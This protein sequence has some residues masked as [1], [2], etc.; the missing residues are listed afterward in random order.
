MV[1]IIEGRA[2]PF[3]ELASDMFPG[4]DN[5]RQNFIPFLGAGVSISGRQFGGGLKLTGPPPK[6]EDMDETIERLGLKGKG[7]TFMEMAILLAYLVQMAEEHNPLE[8]AEQI[9]KRLKEEEDYPPS[10]GEL[11]ELFSLRAHYSMFSSISQM[12]RGLFPETLFSADEEEQIQTLQ[13]LSKVTRIASPPD[14]LTSISSYYENLRGRDKLWGLLYEVISPKAQ[15][16]ETHNLLADAAQLHLSKKRAKDYLIITTNYDCLM[17]QA[18]DQRQVPYIVLTTKKSK[19]PKVL[20]RCSQN[21]E[22]REDLIKDYRDTRTPSN[23][24]LVK[25]QSTVVIYK[26]HGCLSPEFQFADEGLVVSDN[27]YVEYISWMSK[28]DGIIPSYV[29]ELMRD[30]PFWFLGYSLNDWN[31]RSI[32]EMVK[33]KSNPDKKNIRDISVMYSVRDYEKLFFEKNNILIYKSDLNEFVE[34]IKKN[35][36]SQ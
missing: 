19:P 14:P 17:E 6:R 22:D 15:P 34:N 27:D 33:G 18:L 1:D 25:S 13:L 4:A 31:V 16:T 28:S 7:K 20:I 32:Y 10:A 11:A 30:K 8:S 26:I 29:G 5:N 21:V 9:L 35:R 24:T 2:I 36:P 3:E 23:F 12:L